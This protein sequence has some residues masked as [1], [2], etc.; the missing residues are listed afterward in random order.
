MT[1][2][3]PFES[4]GATVY[5]RLQRVLILHIHH[6]H[7]LCINPSSCFNAV[8]P[9]D[10]DSKLHIEVFVFVLYF[11]VVRCNFDPFYSS[12]HEFGS[13]LRFRLPYISLAEEK[14]AIEVGDVDGVCDKVSI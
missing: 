11:A 2:D 1:L 8:K 13:S 5:Q 10:N 7:K 6:I 9:A 3:C 4:F 14:L 12:L